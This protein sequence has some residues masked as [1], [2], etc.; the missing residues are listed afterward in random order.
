MAIGPLILGQ[1]SAAAARTPPVTEAAA[2]RAVMG[3]LAAVA[4]ATLGPPAQHPPASPD[5]ALARAVSLA[6][7]SAVQRQGGLGPLMADLVQAAADPAAPLP[8]QVRAA[9]AQVLGLRTPLGPGV[10]AQDLRTAVARSGLFLEARLAAAPPGAPAAP[11]ADLKAALLIARQALSRW[12]EATE[13]APS[14]APAPAASAHAAPEPRPGPHVPAPAPPY[15]NGPTTAQPPAAPGLAADAAPRAMA[16]RLAGETDG[17]LAR[18]ELMQAAS[19]PGALAPAAPAATPSEAH[20]LFELPFTAPQGSGVVQFALD[21]EPAGPGAADAAPVWRARF[22]LDLEPLGPL[23]AQVAL[24]GAR[25]SVGLWAERPQSALALRGAQESL[26]A[27]LSAAAYAPEVAV[28]SGPP[29]AAAPAP[30]GAFV[31]RSS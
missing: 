31:D 22:S 9:V 21:R 13:P 12:I 29:P 20:W 16:R 5:A 30:V 8:P 27:E 17:A 26:L 3:R 6:V 14:A 7:Q 28:F 19:L 15:R 24:H 10:S 2:V 4:Q 18:Q 25:A 23:H 1:A 11:P